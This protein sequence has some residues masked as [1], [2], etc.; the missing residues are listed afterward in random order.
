MNIK[1]W[2]EDDTIHAIILSQVVTAHINIYYPVCGIYNPIDEHVHLHKSNNYADMSEWMLTQHHLLPFTNGSELVTLCQNN[3]KWSIYPME[4]Y[5]KV[6][7]RVRVDKFDLILNT[8]VTID[9]LSGMSFDVIIHILLN[10][11]TS[12][13]IKYDG[14]YVLIP[15][16]L[17]INL[18]H[19]VHQCQITLEVNDPEITIVGTR[20]CI[21]PNTDIKFPRHFA[22]SF[23]IQQ[24]NCQHYL[25][26]NYRINQQARFSDMVPYMI[27]MIQPEDP[28]MICQ[29]KLDKFTLRLN[30]Q[31]NYNLDKEIHDLGTV[32]NNKIYGVPFCSEAW[33]DPSNLFNRSKT[34]GYSINLYRVD[35]HEIILRFDPTTPMI[36]Y[37]IRI[38]AVTHIIYTWYATVLG[39]MYISRSNNAYCNNL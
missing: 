35:T 9:G 37:N 12:N 23:G 15:L 30:Q 17:H 11:M 29:V 4:Y 1:V 20:Y 13:P 2:N 26:P 31:A 25:G 28:S 32:F 22:K 39:N 24:L 33:D 3:Y 8:K 36:K 16:A 38:L 19:F 18:E 27:I 14:D 10:S 7:I 21:P 6:W 34:T 5:D